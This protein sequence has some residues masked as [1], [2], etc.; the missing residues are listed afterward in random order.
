MGLRIAFYILRLSALQTLLSSF[1]SHF[2]LLVSFSYV[3]A[4]A[5]V[6]IMN[7]REEGRLGSIRRLTRLNLQVWGKRFQCFTPT[8]LCS[9]LEKYGFLFNASSCPSQKRSFS[10]NFYRICRI[11]VHATKG[12]INLFKLFSI[13]MCLYQYYNVL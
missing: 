4:I 12:V 11:I 1:L 2:L 10:V 6:K 7:R 5:S 3:V 9:A 8:I 13:F